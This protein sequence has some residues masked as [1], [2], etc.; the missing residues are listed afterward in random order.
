MPSSVIAHTMAMSAMSP[1]VIHIF[2]P[3]M[4][5]SPPRFLRVGLHVGRVGAAVRLGQAEAADDLAARHCGQVLLLLL[6]GAEGVDRIHAQRAT[7]P[8]RSCGCPSRRARAP[9]R[10]VRSRRRSARRS[11]IPRARSRAVPARRAPESARCG[12]RCSS[13]HFW[14]IGQHLLVDQAA[15]GVLHHALFVGERLA[16]ARRGPADLACGSNAWSRVSPQPGGRTRTTT[17]PIV[18]PVSIWR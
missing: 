11:R 13:K 6:L 2:E 3:L 16:D 15:D 10:S 4:T 9:G 18:R 17:L 5:Q 8:R 12:K 14:M 1:L 7:A